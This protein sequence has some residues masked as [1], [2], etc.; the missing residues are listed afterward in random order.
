MVVNLITHDAAYCLYPRGTLIKKVTLAQPYS[1][2]PVMPAA[3]E[4]YSRRGWDVIHHLPLAEAFGVNASFP[5]GLRHVG[6]SL[7]WK[8]PL[9]PLMM[10]A[11]S[12][13][14]NNSWTVSYDCHMV[15][16]V[17]ATLFRAQDLKFSYLLP[18]DEC[19]EVLVEKYNLMKSTRPGIEYVS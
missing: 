10:D 18:P 5:F 2:S 1:L 14:E 7:T 3:L 17:S 9:E 6:D 11:P 16:Y 13:I 4:K 19:R 8:I 15:P 12:L